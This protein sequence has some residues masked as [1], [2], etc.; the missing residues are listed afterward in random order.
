MLVAYSSMATVA[1]EHGYGR[2]DLTDDEE[3]RSAYF[4]SIAQT[5]SLLSTG[6]SK[7]TVGFFL[8]RLVYA[9]WMKVAIWFVMLFMGIMSICEF[10]PGTTLRELLPALPFLFR[11]AN[12]Y[13]H[14]VNSG[15]NLHL[16]SLQALRLYLGREAR[17][18]M[19]QHYSS[20][21]DLGSYVTPAPSDQS[22]DGVI[23]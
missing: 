14:L 19:H 1:A 12:P 16:G 20:V 4:R 11:V 7:A 9:M 5:F 8:L 18:R 17:R 13:N 23:D 21:H 22:P 15:R 10:I 2:N 6:A 3:A